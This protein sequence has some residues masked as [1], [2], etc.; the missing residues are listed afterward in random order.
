MPKLLHHWVTEQA[1][2]RPEAKAVVGEADC[3]TYAQLEELSNKLARTLREA[4]C[5]KGDRVCL[6]MPKSPMAIAAILGIYKVDGIYVPLDLSSPP[7]RLALMLESCEN[8]W[9]LAA[10]PVAGLLDEVFRQDRF[11]DSVRVGWMEH[12]PASGNY[13]K[14]EFTLEEVERR[15]AAPVD[16]QTSRHDPAHILFTSGSTGTPKG[17]VITHSNVIHFIEWAIQYFHFSP[18][19]RLSGH[20]PLYFDLSFFDIFGTFAAGA[21]LH[22]V[23]PELNLLPHKLAGFIRRAELTQFFSVPSVL[24]YMAKFDV[25]KPED[26]PTL[27]RLLWC[28]EVFPT[29]G[30]IYWM[31]RLPH[32]QFTNLYG[33][34]E[35]TIASSF[36]T[37]PRCPTDEKALIPIGTAC[38]GEELLVLDDQLQPLPPNTTGD[39]YIRGVGL[40]PGYWKDPEETRRVFLPHPHSS[41]PTG[42]IYKTGDLAKIDEDGLVYFLGRADSQIKSRG[43]RIELGE[44]EAALNAVDAIHECAVL[45]IE[46]EGF[47]GMVICCAYVPAPGREVTPVA[48]REELSKALPGYMIPVR[49]MALERLPHNANV[50]IDRRKI[51]EEFRSHETQTH[52]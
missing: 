29:P 33:P 25:V 1:A 13:F 10:G 19:D 42:R 2:R 28:G 39:L 15:S 22:L 49:W 43:Y 20:T 34:T 17:V 6:L 52:R 51:K 48:L 30:L 7:G 47:D 23:P 14:P 35:T 46:T 8:K 12:G 38:E 4:G 45:A 5:R 31:Q 16:S 21:Q 9:V 3:L 27:R 32:V 18:L 37:V 41:D 36:Y 24:N 50:K 40:S 26:F 44:I 11:R